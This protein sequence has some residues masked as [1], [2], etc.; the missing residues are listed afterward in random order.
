MS[1]EIDIPSA[2]VILELESDLRVFRASLSRH[3]PSKAAPALWD[4]AT[5]RM[6]FKV[7][8]MSTSDR[9]G[10]VPSMPAELAE[11][12]NEMEPRAAAVRVVARAQAKIAGRSMDVRA[13]ATRLERNV[14]RF[15]ETP[16]GQKRKAYLDRSLNP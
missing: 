11:E 13:E 10:D 4:R 12:L 14:E 8:Q 16:E 3:G 2:A 15:L 7:F 9:W 5:N 6:W 1:D